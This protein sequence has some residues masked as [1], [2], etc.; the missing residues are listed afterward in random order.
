MFNF[1]SSGFG[2]SKQRCGKWS[3][4]FQDRTLGTGGGRHRS[5]IDKN[6]STATLINPLAPGHRA[7]EQA[8]GRPKAIQ[9]EDQEGVDHPTGQRPDLSEEVIPPLKEVGKEEREGRATEE[10]KKRGNDG[11]GLW[12][13]GSRSETGGAAGAFAFWEGEARPQKVERDG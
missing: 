10:T 2:P 4:P 3:W 1:W 13:N 6:F 8:P 11:D 5:A 9:N 12:T 7:G